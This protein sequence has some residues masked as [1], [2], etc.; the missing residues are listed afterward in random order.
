MCKIVELSKQE[1]EVMTE[2]ASIGMGHASQAL[3]QLLNKKIEITLPEVDIIPIEKIGEYF[4]Q[5]EILLGVVIQILGDMNGKILYL[6]KKTATKRLVQLLNETDQ[7][8]D[9]MEVSSIKEIANILSGSYLNALA[10]FADISLL[11]SLPHLAMDTAASIFDLA[12]ISDTNKMKVIIVKSKLSIQNDSFE[13]I[14]SLML[15]ID[16]EQLKKFTDN[17]VKKYTKS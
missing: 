7:V 13:A 12:T 11:P 15:E 3:G 14:G 10:Q 5:Q 1:K 2:V 8:D 4:P 9:E 16:E 6:F 17:L